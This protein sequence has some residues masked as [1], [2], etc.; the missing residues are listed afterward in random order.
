MDVL[1]LGSISGL[2]SGPGSLFES[3]HMVRVSI[4]VRVKVR[5]SIGVR[6]KVRVRTSVRVRVRSVQWPS[7]LIYNCICICTRPRRKNP[8][9]RPSTK[10]CS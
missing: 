4:G 5:V 2:G 7:P 3:M 1:G 9:F 8:N 6:V 10:H